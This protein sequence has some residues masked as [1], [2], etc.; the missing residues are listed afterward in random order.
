MP[1]LF[2]F[3]SLGEAKSLLNFLLD[4]K[5]T[6]YRK[7]LKTMPANELYSEFTE[8]GISFYG[9]EVIFLA[10]FE[11]RASVYLSRIETFEKQAKM[12]NERDIYKKLLL[13][14]II[15]RNQ[16]EPWHGKSDNKGRRIIAYRY[17]LNPINR[18]PKFNFLQKN[19][20]N[21]GGQR[22]WGWAFFIARYYDA[23]VYPVFLSAIKALSSENVLS[24][25]EAE[26]RS[27]EIPPQRAIFKVIKC[28]T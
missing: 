28:T 12:K 25:N 6:W 9:W 24:Y 13:E 26:I 2:D 20:L 5:S 22:G 16:Q 18:L 4:S 1:R 21:W 8:S 27:L 19:E 3:K 11:S 14:D 17:Q 15:L 10:E 23:L 7:R